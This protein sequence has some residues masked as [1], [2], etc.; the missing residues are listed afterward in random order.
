MKPILIEPYDTLFFRDSIP[1]SA[2]QGRGAGARLPLPSTL[3]E[4]F[5]GSLLDAYGRSGEVAAFRP[6]STTEKRIPRKGGWLGKGKTVISRG[7]KDFQSL[8]IAGPFPFLVPHPGPGDHP[9]GVLFPLPLDVIFA[10]DGTAHTL[11]L[12]RADSSL[13][14]GALP[15]IA[16]SPAPVRKEQTSGFL[17]AAALSG[18]LGGDLSM[19]KSVVAWKSVQNLAARFRDNFTPPPTLARTSVSAFLPGRD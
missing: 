1:M 11:S 5:R 6:K 2:G 12:R 9:S 13:H 7:S 16:V 17:T 19:L 10:E 8:R 14:S 4:A 18:Y 15:V 3:H